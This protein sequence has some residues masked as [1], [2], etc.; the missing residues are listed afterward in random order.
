MGQRTFCNYRYNARTKIALHGLRVTVPSS[1]T[2]TSDLCL[3][4]PP[5]K[6][7]KIMSNYFAV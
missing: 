3:F 7:K 2:D 5:N 6:E 1:I 4:A